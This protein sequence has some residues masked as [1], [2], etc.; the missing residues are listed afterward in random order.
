MKNSSTIF[1]LL[2]MC[3]SCIIL[4]KGQ[5]Y[6]ENYSLNNF[7][8]VYAPVKPNF[9]ASIYE[10]TNGEYNKFLKDL[11]TQGKAKF[12]KQFVVDSMQ[13]KTAFAPADYYV[14]HYHKHPMYKDHPVVNITYEGAKAYCEWLTEKYKNWGK[15]VYTKV[16]FRLPTKMEWK[17]A[18]T[19][20]KTYSK[21]PWQNDKL[22]NE[23]GEYYA[24][25]LHLDVTTAK[26]T[27]ISG[28]KVFIV[29]PDYSKIE[30]HWIY[31]R[32]GIEPA[33]VKSFT[34]NNLGIFNM[35]GNV[36]EML[37][38]KGQTKGGNWNSGS[39]YLRIDADDE[40]GGKFNK[41]SPFVG[42]RV[43]VEVIEE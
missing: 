35:A 7:L 5:I 41:A 39:Y 26:D 43:F 15:G 10:V 8:E 32:N 21:Y 1:L 14:D 25:F 31:V 18:A 24:N 28:E 33:P 16:V 17:A 38:E 30:T 19:G 37:L 2:L 13:W 23:K 34:P 12:A 6:K 42:F 3:S 9:Y 22:K 29:K 11:I 36:S 4:K 20:S 40:F 27:I